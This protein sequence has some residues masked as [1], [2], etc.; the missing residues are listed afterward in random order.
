LNESQLNGRFLYG[1]TPAIAARG[2]S[3]RRFRKRITRVNKLLT[4]VTILLLCQGCATTPSSQ[5]AAVHEVDASQVAKCTLI[6]TI[7]GKS[8]VGGFG[9]VGATNAVVDAKEQAAGLGANTIVIMSV[10]GGSMRAPGT[11][12][13]KAYRCN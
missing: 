8:L 13:A 10:D 9:T 4:A 12:T 3:W 11:A 6:S 1:A 5:A 2:T 7:A